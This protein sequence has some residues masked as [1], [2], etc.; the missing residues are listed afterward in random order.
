MQYSKPMID[1]VYEIRRRV[2]TGMKPSIKLANPEMLQELADYHH[3]CKDTVTRTLIKELL[4]LTGAPWLEQLND[5]TDGAKIPPQVAKVYRGQV[6]L[7][8][9]PIA[10]AAKPQKPVRIYRGQVVE[11]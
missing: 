10:D 1:L 4:S 6:S 2:D 8:N 7:V 9:A 11:G 5:P 3:R